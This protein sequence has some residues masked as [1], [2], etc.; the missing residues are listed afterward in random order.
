VSDD[1][2]SLKPAT[3]GITDFST[4]ALRVRSA[5][6]RSAC[7][8]DPRRLPE[9]AKTLLLHAELLDYEARYAEAIGTI[10]AAEQILRRLVQRDPAAHLD[11]LCQCL[12]IQSDLLHEQGHTEEAVVVAQE[13]LQFAT[14]LLQHRPDEHRRRRYI[15]QDLRKYFLHLD[16][17]EEALEVMLEA[18]D[19]RRRDACD[20]GPDGADGLAGVLHTLCEDLRG[21]GRLDQALAAIGE[22]VELDRAHPAVYSDRFGGPR[23]AQ[24]VALLSAVLAE[25]GRRSE[26]Q[27]FAIEA[28]TILLPH[29][30]SDPV[31][32]GPAAS[33]MLAQAER[34]H[35]PPWVPASPRLRQIFAAYERR[36]NRAGS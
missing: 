4:A 10:L 3:T 25:L 33:A 8:L 31:N 28:L 9:L 24:T 21:L 36:M 12:W 14:A 6:L 15:L 5:Q 11:N 34:V 2:V 19:D 18:V 1:D 27:D 7:E 13:A 22:A 16:R 32:V 26:A 35:E 23:A 17:A 29:F 30:E 20:T